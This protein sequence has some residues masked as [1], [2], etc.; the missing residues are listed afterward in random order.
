M[1]LAARVHSVQQRLAQAC[2]RS[3]RDPGAVTLL[4]VTKG[5]PPEV[6]RAA[7]EC[8]L[9]LFGEN[10]VQEAKA[11]IPL[12]PGRSRW[13]MIGHLQTNKAR[14]AVRC[15]ELIESVDSLHLAQ[16]IQGCAEK[17]GRTLPV[18]LEVNVAGESAKYGYR[19][20][21]LLAELEAL[22]GLRRLEIHGLMTLAPWTPD[23]EKVRPIF[24]RLRE[25]KEQC[26]QALGAP[27]PHLSMGMTGDFEVAIEEGAT[28]VRIGTAIFGERP[29]PGKV[30]R[31]PAPP[32]SNAGGAAD[33]E[34]RGP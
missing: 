26:E 34:S 27:L 31:Q 32:P 5:Q 14:D 4:A 25:L 12:C 17:A 18:L 9:S 10:K 15:F 13:H 21:Q 23:A 22:N 24:R 19:P 16:E 28:L 11:K 33:L 8:G 1:D 7:V 29:P 3:G 6:V 30:P 2:E 20:E